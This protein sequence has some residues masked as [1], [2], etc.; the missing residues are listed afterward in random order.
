MID[1]KSIADLAW[2]RALGCTVIG[3]PRSKIEYIST[4]GFSP[5]RDWMKRELADTLAMAE[6]VLKK[7]V[8]E[9]D[10]KEDKA[11]PVKTTWIDPKT[12]A[13]YSYNWGFNVD[14]NIPMPAVEKKLNDYFKNDVNTTKTNY[15]K[16]SKEKKNMSIKNNR[17][18]CEQLKNLIAV[19]DFRITEDPRCTPEVEIVGHIPHDRMQEFYDIMNGNLVAKVYPS[20]P[21]CKGIIRRKNT[22][23]VDWADGTYTIIVLEDGKEDMDV[24]HTFCIAFT[25][26]ML[27]ST[28]EIMRTIEKNDTDKI[29][30]P[31]KE[32]EEKK[33]KQADEEAKKL[34]EQME[35]AEFEA[36]VQKVMF[37][38]RVFN[39]A[40]RRMELRE[41]K[42]ESK[43]E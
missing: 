41:K 9:P 6:S 2:C 21:Q 8:N 16:M 12:N 40:C 13:E 37:E 39:E 31:K 34:K 1:V 14:S 7:V 23:R 42:N 38:D 3:E 19:R 43:E 4:A 22:T 5:T 32:A 10:K 36:A 30:K 35:A 15:D 28:S 17:Y 11:M 24:F 20:F 25:K 18:I 33:R 27:G 29:E 26:K